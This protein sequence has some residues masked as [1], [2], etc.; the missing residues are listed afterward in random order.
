MAEI[1]IFNDDAFGLVELTAALEEVE[2]LPQWLGQI[3]IFESRAV[4][5]ETVA[6]EKRDQELTLIQT[7]PRGAPPVPQNQRKRDIRDFR[8]SRIFNAD[9]LTAAEVQGIR[10]FGSETEFEQVQTEVLQRQIQLRNNQELTHEHMR[11][12]AIQGIVLDA[13]GTTLYNWFNE[14]S[15]SQPAEETINFATLIDG[16]F[17]AYCNNVIRTMQKAARGAWQ[18][19]TQVWALAG[20]EF[21][22]ALVQAAE[23][24]TTYL[25]WTAAADLRGQNGS[26][27]VMPWDVF[28]FG[29]I[30]WQNYRGTDDGSKVGVSSKQV[31]F[32]PRGSPGTFLRVNSPGETF[33]TVNQPGQEFYPMVIPDDKRNAYV[34]LELYSYPLYICTR[35][36]MLLR[37]KIA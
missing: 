9:H 37:A 5:T 10:A 22:D 3:G 30:Y 1:D 7:S 8:T 33:D 27:I 34:D 18:P 4:R 31:K 19:G 2:Y 21:Y 15:I 26:G 28:N 6:I 35:P 25:G 12:G 29:G 17:R 24:R 16:K 13:D 20:D 14:W 36:R 23:V 11:L 32:F